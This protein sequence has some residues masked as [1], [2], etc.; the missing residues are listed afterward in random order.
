VPRCAAAISEEARRP[1]QLAGTPIDRRVQLDEDWLAARLDEVLT[2]AQIAEPADC[3]Q[4]VVSTAVQPI[5][6]RR[7][8]D[9]AAGAV[10][11][12]DGQPPVAAGPGALWRATGTADILQ[13]FDIRTPDSAPEPAALPTI[14]NV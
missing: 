4:F 3:D 1:N 10:H 5:R 6:R 9:P 8:G 12:V 7:F 2:Q 14:E 13:R 11:V